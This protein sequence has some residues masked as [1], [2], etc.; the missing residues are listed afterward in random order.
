MN[1]IQKNLYEMLIELDDICRRNGIIYYLAGGTALGAVRNEGFLPWD[2]DIDLYITRD[3][4]LKLEKA[5]ESE[6]PENR[7]IITMKNTD[8]YFNPI[9]RYVNTNTTLLYRSQMLCGK[10]AGQHIEMLI[11][12]PMPTD[13][14]KIEDYKRHLLVYTELVTPYFVVNRG[15]ITPDSYFDYDLYMHYYKMTKKIGI[16]ATLKMLED[17]L[18]CYSEEECEV[19]CMRWGLRILMYDKR[20]Y[21]TPRLQK[22]EDREFYVAEK[23]EEIFRIA[24]GDTWMYIPEV[25]EQVTHNSFMDLETPFEVYVDRYMK[26]IDKKLILKA[27]KKNKKRL[28]KT[29]HDR[30]ECVN[31]RLKINS[32]LLE[33]EFS[34]IWEQNYHQI[35]KALD[36][37]DFEYLGSIYGAIDRFL[38]TPSSKKYYAVV[39]IGEQ[40]I[41]PYLKLLLAKGLYSKVLALDSRYRLWGKEFTDYKTICLIETAKAFKTVSRYIYDFKDIKGAEDELNKIVAP[42]T[43]NIVYKRNCYMIKLECHKNEPEKVKEIMTE[44]ENELK[45]SFD[46]ELAKLLGDCYFYGGQAEK[47]EEFYKKAHENTRNGIM[48]LDIFKKTGNKDYLMVK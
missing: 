31:S 18:F 25:E 3:N 21:G 46:A 4:W 9:P 22:F 48:L 6:I 26:H 39:N 24:Y 23:A 38:F 34:I 37:N 27:Y 29:L 5:L 7:S 40:K 8:Y 12:D 28:M 15:V 10:A 32:L 35:L 17:K 45:N 20:M 30:E 43:E 16:E 1:D 11:M 13:P 41:Y 47:A 36:E 2:D 33:E 42:Y 44:L 19:L 14:E